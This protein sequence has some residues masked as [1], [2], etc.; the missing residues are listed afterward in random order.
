[1]NIIITERLLIRPV[2][3]DD[4][5]AIHRYAGDETI[6]M[7]THLPN[8]SVDETRRFTQYAVSEWERIEPR[9]RE[10]VILLRNNGELI[11]GVNLEAR[12]EPLTYEIGWTVRRDMRG[13]GFATEA[14]RALLSYAF[15]ALRAEAVVSVCDARNAASERVMRKL[16]MTLAGTGTRVYP[17]TKEK[18]EELRYAVTR[19]AFAL[20]AEPPAGI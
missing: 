19:A 7:M 5:E 1:M 17:K 12:P 11:G 8:A 3:A 20:A 4:A 10:Y 9:D 2:R 14:A 15:D 6:T 16:G 13:R 18:A